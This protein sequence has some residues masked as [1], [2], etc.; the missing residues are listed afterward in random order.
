MSRSFGYDRANR[1]KLVENRIISAN[2]REMGMG[3]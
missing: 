1:V 2:V 3:E